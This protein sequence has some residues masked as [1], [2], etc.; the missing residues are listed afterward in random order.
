VDAGFLDHVVQT[1]ATA[2]Q[3]GFGI[4]HRVS[5]GL[6]GLVGSVAWGANLITV[7]QAGLPLGGVLAQLCLV[8][9]SFAVHVLLITNMYSWAFAFFDLFAQ[10]GA[11]ITGG[12]FSAAQFLQPSSV[13]SLG[14]RVSW[15]LIE[16]VS[17]LGVVKIITN[18]G[19]LIAALLAVIVIVLAFL[20]ITKDIILTILEFHLAVMLAPVLFPWAILSHTAEFAA[21]VVSWFMAGCIRVLLI[22]ASV[23]IAVPLMGELV[24]TFTAG[25][26]PTIYSSLVMLGSALMLFFIVNEVAKRAAAVGGRGYALGLPGATIVPP[27]VVSAAG[28]VLSTGGSWAVQGA[29]RLMNGPQQ[30]RR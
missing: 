21:F 9:V 23:G 6:L 20:W 4:L 1:Y 3:Q 26:D 19:P 28:A 13:W 10:W 2:F 25:G 12:T 16:F 5:L 8:L 24:P 11:S 30:Q 14:F 7:I 17:G 18:I 29:S 15:P 22:I 27:S